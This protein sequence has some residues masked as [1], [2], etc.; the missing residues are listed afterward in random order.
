MKTLISNISSSFLMFSLI[1]VST[2]WAQTPDGINTAI[3]YNSITSQ[4]ES[5]LERT[6]IVALR[7]ITQARSDI[8]RKE[9][10]SALIELNKS[11]M[12]LETIK[13]NLSTTTVKNFIWVARK[14]LEYEPSQQVLH[15]LEPIYSS[16]NMISAYIPTDKA[17]R[18]VDRAK[19][20]LEKDKKS[21]A[22]SA[23][24]RADKSLVVIEVEVSL[25]KAQRYVTM[26]QECLVTNNPKKANEVL[27]IAEQ[28]A[29]ALYFGMNTPMV[30]ARRNIWLAFRNYSPAK[31]SA[32][33]ALLNQARRNLDKASITS[34]QKGKEEL[35]KLSSEVA[36]L[37]NKLAGEGNAVES[38]IKSAWEKSE[39]LAERS[40]AYVSS[41]YSEA[42]ATLKSEDSLIEARL[43]VM[44]A[45]SYQVT[46]R[47]PDK[48]VRELDAALSF[49][50]K[51]EK[52][53][54]TDTS[55]R[56]KMREI[57]NIILVL[58]LTPN[59]Q[60]ITVQDRYDAIKEDLRNLV[61]YDRLSEQ[62]RKLQN[63]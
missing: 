11:E 7:H 53:S 31:R 1:A 29:T 47:E 12:L 19:G 20:Y 49:L 45:E 30:Q 2:S 42:M 48:A 25:L 39:A 58:K 4:E 46:T 21:E 36:V 26:A 35:K 56:R 15:D 6:A 27:K 41:Y 28:W 59:E 63:M 34:N 60:D 32:S 38:E 8:H 14:H 23:L 22:G 5:T 62:I 16:L 37:E 33:V 50:Q 52:D 24:D 17:K 43:H 9:L 44:Y 55:E 57:G 18:Y 13:D 40:V 10:A 61:D 3:Q 51:A 54:L